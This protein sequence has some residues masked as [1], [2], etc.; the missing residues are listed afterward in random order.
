MTNRQIAVAGCLLALTGSV[1]AQS[2]VNLFGAVDANIRYIAYSQGHGSAVSM[3]SFGGSPSFIGLLGKEDLGNGYRATFRIDAGF[4]PATGQAAPSAW[5]FPFFDRSAWVGLESP[6]GVLHFGREWSPTYTNMW[7]YDPTYNLGVGNLA[8]LSNLL[9]HAIV[10]NYDWNANSI[11][12]YT[13]ENHYGISAALQVAP[14]GDGLGCAGNPVCSTTIGSFVGGR[15]VYDL[16]SFEIAGA[17]GQT[18]I[19]SNTVAP[20]SSGK[21]TQANLGVSYDFKV[22]KLMLALND[23]SFVGLKERRASIGVQIPVGVHF[24]WASYGLTRTDADAQAAGLYGAQAFAL[25]FIYN[26]SKSTAAYASVAYLKNSGRGTLSVE[27]V[28][29]YTGNTPLGGATTGVEI[30]IRTAF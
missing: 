9:S 3:G 19:T 22:A 8:H 27:D 18:G 2:S 25:G 23:E 10:P 12:Y 1:H 17:L 30:G 6:F 11:T 24:A 7:T 20:Q 21:W 13:P 5:N 16:G 28:N 4:V 29:S 14:R 15:L 26:L